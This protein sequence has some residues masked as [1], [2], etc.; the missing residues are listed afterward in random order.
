MLPCVRTHVLL[1]ATLILSACG[2]SAETASPAP[3]PGPPDPPPAPAGAPLEHWTRVAVAGPLEL[4]VRDRLAE[5]DGQAGVVFRLHD[6]G[7]APLLADLRSTARV[8]RPGAPSTLRLPL[9]DAQVSELSMISALTQVRPDAPATYAVPIEPAACEITRSVPLGGVLVALD[10]TR[11]VELVADGVE[12]E[13]SCAAPTPAPSG[14]M[15]VTDAGELAAAGTSTEAFAT[16]ADPLLRAAAVDPAAG[17]ALLPFSYDARPVERWRY[18]ACVS[19]GRCPAR[20]VPQPPGSIRAP[21][22]G[23]SRE[24][25]EAFCATRSL[26]APTDE[27]IAAVRDPGRALIVP[28]AGV[29]AVSIGLRCARSESDP[30]PAP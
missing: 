12:A 4:Q 1:I 16:I 6:H 9:S 30:A 20:L 14:T 19:L 2:S 3:S 24:G 22:V 11:T 10:D 27:E 28:P 15:W 29:D 17:V 26:R 13:L 21:A 5:R 25:V 23:M 18:D 8:V 7:D